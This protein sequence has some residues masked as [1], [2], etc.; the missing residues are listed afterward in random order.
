MCVSL[1]HP[2][3]PAASFGFTFDRIVKSNEYEFHIQLQLQ[4]RLLPGLFAAAAQNFVEFAAIL[5]PF[6]IYIFIF[7]YIVLFFGFSGYFGLCLMSPFW[8]WYSRVK[9]LIRLALLKGVAGP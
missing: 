1:G 6:F 7:L 2:P 3:Y 4:F 5:H 8:K 9:T